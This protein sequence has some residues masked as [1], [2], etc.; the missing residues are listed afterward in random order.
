MPNLKVKNLDVKF[1]NQLTKTQVEEAIERGFA[2]IDPTAET[3]YL[4]KINVGNM[5]MDAVA[6]LAK[7]L[8]LEL[9]QQGITNY[10]FIPLC[11]NGI[12]D[13]EIIEVPNEN[14]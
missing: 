6:N 8:T 2:G 12:Q 7:A 13:I 3:V 11:D 14:A 5:R 10:I 4:I 9:K 1:S